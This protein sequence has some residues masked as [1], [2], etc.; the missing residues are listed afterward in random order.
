MRATG[1]V[2]TALRRA[3][4]AVLA[5][6]VTGAL[7][8]VALPTAPAD[9]ATPRL[10]SASPTVRLVVRTMPGAAAAVTSVA[11]SYGAERVGQVRPLHAVSF[12]VT[13]ADAA[14][15]RQA[16]AERRDVRSVGLA[17]RRQLTD[18]PADPRFGEQ[19]SY[20]GAVGI[21]A[22]WDRGA[23]GGSAV[24]IAV[25][26]SGVDVGHP[27]LV[28]K[29]AAAYN[30]VTGGS[31][32]HDVVGHGTGTASVAAAATGNGEGIAGAG[33]DASIMAV[34]VA[35]VTGRIF[36]D[37]LARGIV[38]ATDHGADVVNLSLGGP[39]SDPLE[40]A[41]VAYAVA[42][43][44]LV[45]A[46]AG[47]EGS[48]IRQYPGALP[49]VLA[50]GATTASGS[51]RAAFSSFGPWVD[52]AAPGR[53]VVA[54]T[55]GGGYEAADGTSYSAPLVS[56]AAALLAAY[57]PGRTASQ[58]AQALLGG[59]DAA[60]Y[61]FAHGLL[62]VDRSLDLL[63][64]ATAP[65]LA[66]PA[67][68]TS[69]S[70]RTTVS[71]TSSAPRVTL[72]LG[73]LTATVQVTGGAAAATFDTFGLV[74][75]QPVRAVDCST[76]DQC[77]APAATATVSVDNAGPV[78]T[79]PAA[80]TEVRDDGL[81]VTADAPAE[82]GAVRF[83]IDADG[84]GT[85]VDTSSPFSAVL[86]TARLGDGGHVVH[87][88][89]CRADGSRCDSVHEAQVPITSTRLHPAVTSISPH[90]ISPDGD[91]RRDRATVT[92]RLDRPQ[93]PTLVVRNAA[94]EIVYS[95]VLGRQPAGSHAATWDGRRKGGGTV[96]DG[97]FQLG[98][99]TS[100]GTLKGL[101]GS[102]V[103]VDRTAPALRDARPSSARVLP[104]RDRYLDAVT[105]TAGSAEQLRQLRLEVSTRD[106]TVVRTVR[107]KAQ[108]AGTVAIVWNGRRADGRLVPGSYRLRLV[109]EDTA[110][111]RSRSRARPV[112]V[113][114][115]R[116]VKRSGSSTVAARDTLEDTFADDC[117]DVFRRT[118]GSHD[119]WVSYASGSLCTTG[120]A[121]AAGD[122]QVRLPAAARYGTV[123]VSAFGGR[124]DKRYRDH[125]TVV[126]YD[127]LQNLST[128]RFR[129]GPARAVH[130]GPRVP[131]GPLVIRSRVLRWETLTTGVSWY[132]VKTY[133]VDYTYYV[134]R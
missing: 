43:D 103:T 62:H 71:V 70:G 132:D 91:G 51:S 46:A 53:S 78:V 84:F 31:D 134:L 121:Y 27:D 17:H 35:D 95:K 33:R 39:T 66:A 30:A 54:A 116:L 110:G 65:T 7:A 118:S 122:H 49:E 1:P 87:V 28:G 112:V 55:P 42:H 14:A 13:R 117:S 48:K 60:R 113:S 85:V 76:V 21:P 32:V 74:G 61:G 125:A 105:F 50:V 131:A 40:R 123:R 64:P 94:G 100:D 126:L 77:A 129:L 8:A 81:A 119:G 93:T 20:F 52:L 47:N 88:Q 12:Q 9:A 59:T 11:R 89:V 15:L 18:E 34:K 82:A 102:A 16:L 99:S 90:A 75:A 19:R 6:L 72:G 2:R 44:V 22:A 25:V 10:E 104:V 80:G 73:D 101:A 68:G 120:D 96:L 86:P 133:R 97:T 98:V 83:E 57:R 5:A 106:G 111:N 108:S 58:L 4:R 107:E 128:V 24:R 127:G 63:P 124:A 3:H 23:R 69:V 130:R 56:G 114:G 36:T 26:D 41:A 79:S 45:V 109:G 92:Y 115:Q 37:D 67:D 38:W 29:V